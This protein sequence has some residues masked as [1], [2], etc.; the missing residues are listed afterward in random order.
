MLKEFRVS[1]EINASIEEVW[2][3]LVD[4]KSQSEW[5][6]LTKVW[7]SVDSGGTSGIGTE[8]SA[9][10]GIGSIGVLDKMRI[11]KWEPPLFCAVEHF[12]KVIK[13]IG[14]FRLTTIPGDNSE[15]KVRFDW[16]EEIDAPK[17]MLLLIKPGTLLA[18]AYSLR[19]FARSFSA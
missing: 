2:E 14:E 19:K 9:F 11:T 10:T 8:I 1:V 13:G 17:L 16:Y 4:W 6:A 5:M 15:T 18:V 3:K 7:S 12:G